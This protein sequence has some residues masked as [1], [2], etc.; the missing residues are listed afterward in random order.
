MTSSDPSTTLQATRTQEL[1]YEVRVEEA[2]SREVITVE[3][4]SSMAEV[5]G[6][7]KEKRLTG[8]PVTKEGNLVGSSALRT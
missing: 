3:P 2:M 8:T 7:L 5:L 1:I 6:I 4:E